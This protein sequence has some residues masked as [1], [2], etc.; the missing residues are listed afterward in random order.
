MSAL[1]SFITSSL[2]NA[3]SWCGLPSLSWREESEWSPPL[4]SGGGGSEPDPQQSHTASWERWVVFC[5]FKNSKILRKAVFLQGQGLFCLLCFQSPPTPTLPPH[6]RVPP[7][8]RGAACAPY[9]TSSSASQMSWETRAAR[10]GAGDLGGGHWTVGGA[11]SRLLLPARW[12]AALPVWAVLPVR[13][14]C[15]P[16]PPQSCQYHQQDA[17]V[18]PA[19]SGQSYHWGG[20][21]STPSLAWSVL[22]D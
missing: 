7:L 13:W 5:C 8:C 18:S 20:P 15:Q 9:G 2:T 1:V 17:P 10:S 14:S 21:V 22:P 16:R 12:S 6:H 11:Q 3:S 4:I 19:R